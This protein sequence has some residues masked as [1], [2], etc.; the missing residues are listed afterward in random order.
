MSDQITVTGVTATDP[1]HIVT[2]EGLAITSFRFASSQRHFD[3]K[4]SRWVEA[5]TNW[6]T[7]SAV[8]ALAINAAASI[9]KGDRLIVR[10]RLRIRDWSDGERSGR[11][12]EIEAD[13]IG[14]DLAYGIAVVTRQPVP[15]EAPDQQEAEQED[16]VVLAAA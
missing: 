13:A 1:R 5:E 11:V 8:R 15:V 9:T 4:T 14:P 16:F 3:R 2:S 10:G 7:V 12:V 6:Y